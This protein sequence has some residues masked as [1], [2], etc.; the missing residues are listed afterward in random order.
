MKK[1]IILFAALTVTVNTCLFSQAATFDKDEIYNT[2]QVIYNIKTNEWSRKISET[3]KIVRSQSGAILR[4]EEKESKKNSTDK[5]KKTTITPKKPIKKVADPTKIILTKQTASGSNSYTVFISDKN[6]PVLPLKSNHEFIEKG[7]LIAV[8]NHNLKY[9]KIIYKDGKFKDIAL[10]EEEL[11]EIFPNIEIIKISEFKN[12][13]YT[14]TKDF[15]SIKTIL[16]LNDTDRSFY[17]Y[18]YKPPRVQ[19]SEVK[20]LIRTPKYDKI[21][22]SHYGDKEGALTINIRRK[23]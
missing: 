5:E 19:V 23:K 1:L 11:H 14:T 15:F 6:K 12:D 9:Y 22:F 17:K 4:I 20:G 7:Q 16:L 10:T 2:E 8:D 13:K 18:S 21:I 3:G